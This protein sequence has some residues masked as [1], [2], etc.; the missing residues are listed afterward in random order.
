MDRH[1]LPFMPTATLPQP[2]LVPLCTH[3]TS[4]PPRA[5][6]RAL[7]PSDRQ[8]REMSI[9]VPRACDGDC[10]QLRLRLPSI[11]AQSCSP[12]R[13]LSHHALCFFRAPSRRSL[14]DAPD[15]DV[16][17]RSVNWVHPPASWNHP[18]TAPALRIHLDLSPSPC[19]SPS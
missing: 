12:R 2:N 19:T 3:A 8:E 4:L 13:D 10:R 15:A 6:T 5:R 16:L 17:G 7:S 18:S 1:P 9:S 11:F 14:H